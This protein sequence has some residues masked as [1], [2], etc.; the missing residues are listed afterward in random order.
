MTCEV[1]EEPADNVELGMVQ[2][3]SD[4]VCLK[5]VINYLMYTSCFSLEN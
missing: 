3:P 4:E 2:K 1:K 5:S